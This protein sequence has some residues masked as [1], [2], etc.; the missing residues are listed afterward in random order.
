MFVVAQSMAGVNRNDDI[1]H[2]CRTPDF[3]VNLVVKIPTIQDV[4]V[5]GLDEFHQRFWNSISPQRAGVGS[6]LQFLGQS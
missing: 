5:E 4:P 2:P 3:T 1:T 6:W